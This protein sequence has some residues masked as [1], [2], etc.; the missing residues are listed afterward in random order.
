MREPGGAF[1]ELR[2]GAALVV[3]HDRLARRYR[4]G[5]ALEQVGDVEL[6][7]SL[8]GGRRPVVGRYSPILA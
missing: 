8:R 3:A 4:V 6:H 7:A 1:V 5:H 2:V